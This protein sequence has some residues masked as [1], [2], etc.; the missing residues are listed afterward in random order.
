MKYLKYLVLMLIDCLFP[1]I[2][3]KISKFYW[4]TSDKV[5]GDTSWD[6]YNFYYSKIKEIMDLSKDDLILDAACGTGEITYLFHKA[7]KVTEND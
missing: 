3:Q 2:S 6:A 5:H 1:N 4:M 7:E